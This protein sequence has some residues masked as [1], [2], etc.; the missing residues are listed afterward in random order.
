MR[1]L[2]RHKAKYPALWKAV[3]GAI[4]S[5]MHAHPEINIPNIDS[6]TKR[7]VGQVL[8]L[9]AGAVA[10]AER[11]GGTNPPFPSKEGEYVPSLSDG[12]QDPSLGGGDAP[13]APTNSTK[14]LT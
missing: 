10:P 11:E 3:E 9:E 1:K 13:S 14:E 2:H 8:A 4:R 5:A 6:V 7:V 12:N